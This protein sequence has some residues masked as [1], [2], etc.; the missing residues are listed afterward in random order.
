[1]QALS[2]EDHASQRASKQ[3][4]IDQLTEWLRLHGGYAHSALTI[5][6]AARA[7]AAQQSA[8]WTALTRLGHLCG[9]LMEI[10]MLRPLLDASQLTVLSRWMMQ[11]DALFARLC[12]AVPQTRLSRRQ[13]EG[14]SQVTVWLGT[15]QLLPVL[16]RS[17]AGC[18]FPASV[19]AGEPFLTAYCLRPRFHIISRQPYLRLFHC[20]LDPT[21]TEAGRHPLSALQV[22]RNFAR[23][24]PP[25]AMPAPEPMD[26][27]HSAA[28]DTDDLAS[29]PIPSVLAAYATFHHEPLGPA[30]DQRCGALHA[31]F[32]HALIPAWRAHSVK[33]RALLLAAAPTRLIPPLVD[34]VSRYL[35]LEGVPPERSAPAD[36]PA[37][38]EM[39]SNSHGHGQD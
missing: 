28:T 7:A 32:M 33:V 5:I 13:S 30:E 6:H 9:T 15:L 4:E 14:L 24:H 36:E 23:D 26:R 20:G 2:S 16:I 22:A 17:Q 8:A 18:D 35:D 11:V 1:M 3:A 19:L 39:D 29:A 10:G 38:T 21:R 25:H 34:V 37:E 31:Q 27:M 12:S